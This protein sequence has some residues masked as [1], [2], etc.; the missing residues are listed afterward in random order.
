MAATNCCWN[1]PDDWQQW[2]NWPGGRAAWTQSLAALG[3]L[4][5]D[6]VCEGTANRHDLVARRWGQ[7]RLPELF[8]DK[9]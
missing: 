3:T 9:L 6:S 1:G 5:R 8:I 2:S 7:R 4:G